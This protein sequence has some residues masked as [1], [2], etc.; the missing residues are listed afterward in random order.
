MNTDPIPAPNET[1][2]APVVRR[3]INEETWRTLKSSIYPGASSESVLMVVDYCRARGLD[4]L[5]RPV[6]LVPMRVKDAKTGREEWRDVVMRGIDELRITAARS[7]SYAGQDVPE[8]GPSI[9]YLG[10]SVP[11]WAEVR[12]YRQ[13]GAERVAFTDRVYFAEACATVTDRGTGAVRLNAMWGKRPRG[14][15]AKCAEAGALRKGFPEDVG[16]EI[17]AEEAH[18][19]DADPEVKRIDVE[20]P[21]EYLRGAHALPELELRWQQVRRQLGGQPIPL[22]IEALYHER[23][24]WLGE[25]RDRALGAPQADRG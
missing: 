12:V 3:G 18:P 1:L 23:R 21:I 13:L 11:E 6:H 16:S 20:D 19:L 15:L 5:K 17:V 24:E 8:F 7:G 4:P 10:L 25:Q 2:P 14:Q 9:E 22:P